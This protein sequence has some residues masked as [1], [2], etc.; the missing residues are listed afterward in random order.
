MYDADI[1]LFCV[2]ILCN[3]L[4]QALAH[5]QLALAHENW[6]SKGVTKT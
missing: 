4:E 2:N 6:E 1:L 5:P 3:L